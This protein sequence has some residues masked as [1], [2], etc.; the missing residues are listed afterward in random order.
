MK[1]PWSLVDYNKDFSKE[2]PHCYRPID[3]FDADGHQLFRIA[4][5]PRGVEIAAKIIECVNAQ[6]KVS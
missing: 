6:E 1:A 5:G 3:L 2:Y 4:D